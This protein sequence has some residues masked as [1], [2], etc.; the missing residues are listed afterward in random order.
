MVLFFKLQ[1]SGLSVGGIIVQNMENMRFIV[2][3]EFE[4]GFRNLK[5]VVERK[6]MIINKCGRQVENILVRLL[7]DGIF[8]IVEKI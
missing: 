5:F 4:G 1:M 7:V 2:D 6:N 8:I 3:R